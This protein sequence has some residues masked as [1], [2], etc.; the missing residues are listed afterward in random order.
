[1]FL[2]RAALGL[3]LWLST[4]WFGKKFFATFVAAKVV[5]L[6]IAFGGDCL[7]LIHGHSTY[8]IF[9]QEVRFSHAF[10]SSINV[11]TALFL[12]PSIRICAQWH[13]RAAIE[14][15]RIYF[16]FGSEIFQENEISLKPAEP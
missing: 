2:S 1:V 9:D 5:R 7:C 3:L 13:A 14:I 12:R 10:V 15:Q 16:Y 11:V 6:S 8:R 4:D